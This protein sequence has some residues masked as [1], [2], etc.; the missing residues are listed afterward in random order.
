MTDDQVRE[1]VERNRARMDSIDK[2]LTRLESPCDGQLM[3]FGD[4]RQLAIDA[5]WM[6]RRLSGQ[7]TL[8]HGLGSRYTDTLRKME[9][10]CKVHKEEM[11]EIAA[12][13]A[14]PSERS[15]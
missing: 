5:R 6:H 4:L 8:L 1:E 15:S 9:L 12:G 2:L 7:R 10:I 14:L 11:A 13:L 3:D